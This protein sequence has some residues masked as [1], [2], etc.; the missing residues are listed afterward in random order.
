MAWKHNY[1]L[2]DYFSGKN[3]FYPLPP[4]LTTYVS[5]SSDSKDKLLLLHWPL[6]TL[7]CQLWVL[8]LIFD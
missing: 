5:Q 2:Q 6:F 8:H 3:V 7:L 1:H 4:E